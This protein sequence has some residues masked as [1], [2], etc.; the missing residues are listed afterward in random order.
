MA[1]RKSKMYKQMHTFTKKMGTTGAQEHV[2]KI[3]KL[4]PA[5]NSGYLKNIVCSIMAQDLTGSTQVERTAL[6]AFTVYLSN[7][8][9]GSWSDD[10]VIA[11]RS[12]AAGGGT[13]SLSARRRLETQDNIDNSN[14]GNVHV[15]V[16]ATDVPI[17]PTSGNELEARISIEAWGRFIL[18]T[19]DDA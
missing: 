1:R 17:A 7:S 8:P 16:E 6:P 11:A 2:A 3:T 13:V 18:M 12:T 10:Q 14:E 19:K 9:S 4:D 15:W 5:L